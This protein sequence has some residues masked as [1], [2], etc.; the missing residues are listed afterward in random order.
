M[1]EWEPRV[2]PG[3]ILIPSDEAIK[4]FGIVLPC[5]VIEIES[6]WSLKLRHFSFVIQCKKLKGSAMCSKC[7]RLGAVWFNGIA[8]P[9]ANIAVEEVSPPSPERKP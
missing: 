1:R 2:E 6:F 7:E 8:D 3:M 4:T 5:A 9:M